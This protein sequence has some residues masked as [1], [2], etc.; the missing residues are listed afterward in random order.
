MYT[1]PPVAA[2]PRQCPFGLLSVNRAY[3]NGFV[4]ND[5]NHRYEA[6][7]DGIAVGH[8]RFRE[9]NG[10]MVLIHTEVDPAYEGHGIGGAIARFALDE[11][12]ERGA[13]VV[14][15]CPFVRAY[16]SHHPE[17]ADLVAE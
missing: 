6:S 13:T 5:S 11:A 16:L 4:R 10:Q 12:R 14:P 15:E 1:P 17:Y 3:N 7:I 2:N 8:L 9:H